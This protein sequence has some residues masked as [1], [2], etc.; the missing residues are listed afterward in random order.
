MAAL[1]ALRTFGT[2]IPDNIIPS[3]HEFLCEWHF[4]SR[5]IGQHRL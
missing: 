1:D 3:H 5:Q 2:I 4:S